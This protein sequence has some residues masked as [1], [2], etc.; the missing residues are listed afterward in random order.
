MRNTISIVLF[1]L[2]FTILFSTPAYLQEPNSPPDTNVLAQFKIEKNTQNILLPVKFQGQ[3]YLFDLDTGASHTLFDIS[4]KDKLGKPK[5]TVKVE[6]EAGRFDAQFF[7]APGAF[8]GPLNLKDCRTVAAVDI[9]AIS[10]ALGTKRHG[11][12]GMNFLKKH[13]LQIDS[14]RGIISFLKPKRRGIFSSLWPKKND[15]PE[16]GEQVSMKYEFFSGIPHIKTKIDGTTVDFMIDTG[17]RAFVDLPNLTASDTFGELESKIFKKVS[18]VL[19]SEDK[20]SSQITPHGKAPSDFTK[21]TIIGRFYVGPLEYKDVTFDEAKESK[22]GMSFFSRHLV[23]FDFPNKRMYLKKG[24]YFDRQTPG[25]ISL[26]DFGFVLR[27]K[28]DDIFVSSVDPNSPAYAKG[29]KQNDII[30]KVDDTNVASYSLTELLTVFISVSQDA[31]TLTF[32][33]KRD[34]DIKQFSF[35]I[36]KKQ[37]RKVD[38][39]AAD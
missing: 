14:D 27:R 8:L 34:D 11:I 33:I 38:P 9:S 15:H 35:T 7:D 19:Q 32:T 29:M 10:S 30:L 22:L 2:L 36:E 20:Q 23:T 6:A 12:I 16:W 31:G 26:K 21:K 39:N 24:S 25:Y 3:E 37:N 18:S 17:Y 5:R 1:A 28:R 13:V 4:L